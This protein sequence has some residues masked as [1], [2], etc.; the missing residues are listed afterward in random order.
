LWSGSVVQKAWAKG[1]PE[2]TEPYK[3]LS[4]SQ[5]HKR[6]N[7]KRHPHLTALDDCVNRRGGAD[8]EKT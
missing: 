5:T 1:V 3:N 4:P 7:H 6:T 8:R 2:P